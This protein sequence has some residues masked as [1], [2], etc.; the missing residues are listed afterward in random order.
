M[1]DPHR[2][3]PGGAGFGAAHLPRVG[4]EVLV[5]FR[6]GDPDMPYILGGLYNS[7]SP[8]PFDLP[9]H[10][11]RSVFKSKSLGGDGAQ[12][13]GLAFDDR[14]GQESVQLHG[15][16]D[17]SLS[18]EHDLA[19]TAGNDQR[20]TVKNHCHVSVGK[21]DQVTVGGIHIAEDFTPGPW[22]FSWFD[23]KLAGSIGHKIETV[24]GR[25]STFTAGAYDRLTGGTDTRVAVLGDTR[26]VAGYSMD[27]VTGKRTSMTMGAVSKYAIGEFFIAS[28]GDATFGRKVQLSAG[29]DLTVLARAGMKLESPDVAVRAGTSIELKSEE[30]SMGARDRLGF[31]APTI[32]FTNGAA[33]A[34]ASLKLQK[35]PGFSFVAFTVGEAVVRVSNKAI[36]FQ[37]GT[38]QVLLTTAGVEISGPSLTIKCDGKITFD[39]MSWDEGALAAFFN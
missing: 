29:K 33:V 27:V 34:Q 6:M 4:E 25:N 39:A 17:Q 32:A 18:A 15:E 10:C 35:D 11:T 36:R 38:S 2:P 14:N 8:P 16:K 23:G 13:S 37:V 1:L 24:F 22:G 31:Y 30:L 26:A 7:N 21:L 28:L 19:V 12:F 5:A 3:S 20:V 9:Q